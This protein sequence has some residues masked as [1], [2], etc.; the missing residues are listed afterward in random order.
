MATTQREYYMQIIAAIADVKKVPIMDVCK[1]VET[2]DEHLL[3]GA[4]RHPLIMEKMAY[5][6][7]AVLILMEKGFADQTDE[8]QF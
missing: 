8:F 4:G 2:M 6:E 5:M 7:K 1:A 3:E